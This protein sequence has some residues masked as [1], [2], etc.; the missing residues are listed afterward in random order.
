[1][2]KAAGVSDFI[3]REIKGHLSTAVSRQYTHLR[4]DD[5][6]AHDTVSRPEIAA[7]VDSTGQNKS[8]HAV[9]RDGSL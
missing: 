6:R 5:K 9:K 7:N 1:M 2:L 4:T 8:R 3:A